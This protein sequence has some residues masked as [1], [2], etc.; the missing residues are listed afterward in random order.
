M[1]QSGHHD[2]L[3]QCPLLGVKRTLIE[4]AAMS[5]FDPKR[6]SAA[7]FKLAD[8]ACI[9]SSFKPRGDNEATGISWRNDRGGYDSAAAYRARAAANHSA[10]WISP[11]RLTR[12]EHQ[13][14]SRIPK[15]PRRSRII[16]M[17]VM[18]RSNFVGPMATTADLAR[19]QVTVIVSALGTAT[20]LA[21][22]AATTTI[23]IVF[24]AGTD[25][26]EAGIVA[27]EWREAPVPAGYPTAWRLALMP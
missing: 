21:A 8:K 22:K 13:S 10:H 11:T 17:V 27:S 19:H 20:A 5:A 12:A 2:A 7:A 6:T 1:A 14:P 4:W 15:G 16:P 25:P 18:S 26:V 24:S 23:P 3:Y 9:I